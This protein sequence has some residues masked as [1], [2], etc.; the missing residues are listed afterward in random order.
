M[1]VSKIK[2]KSDGTCRNTKIFTEDGEDI[3]GK[4]RSFVVKADPRELGP[5]LYATVEF[6]GVELE[7]E[8]LELGALDAVALKHI[9]LAADRLGD[10]ISEFHDDPGAWAEHIDALDT[11]L[12]RHKELINRLRAQQ[13][14]ASVKP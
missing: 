6:M 12:I 2:I 7:A 3:T 8:G 13:W 4:V 10:C 14:Q 1:D 9:A 5:R 11:I